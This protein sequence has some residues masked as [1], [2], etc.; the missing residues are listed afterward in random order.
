MVAFKGELLKG[1]KKAVE[2]LFVSKFTEP[3]YK[4]QIIWSKCA[5]LTMA[6]RVPA[7]KF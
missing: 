1:Q 7:L 2:C 5:R 3:N 4:N 6:N